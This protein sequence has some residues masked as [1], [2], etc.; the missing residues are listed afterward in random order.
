MGREHQEGRDAS[1][2]VR[3]VD[4]A[5]QADGGAFAKRFSQCENGL[6]KIGFLDD[7]IRP[8]LFEELVLLYD[9][10]AGAYEEHEYVERLGR[11]RN[12]GSGTGKDP[13]PGVQAKILELIRDTGNTF[14]L[15]RLRILKKN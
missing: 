12:S 1:L 6:A 8:N 4:D 3:A 14:R 11:H 7:R 13:A 15:R 9:A 2:A 5:A 10:G